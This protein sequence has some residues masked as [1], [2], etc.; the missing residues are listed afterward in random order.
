M[1]KIEIPAETARVQ[2][3]LTPQHAIPLDV[4]SRDLICAV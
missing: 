1:D 4:E 3:M 2:R